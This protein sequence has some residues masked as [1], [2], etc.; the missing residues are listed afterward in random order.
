MT[1]IRRTPR[2]DCLTE[3]LQPQL[4][5]MSART[6]ELL[7]LGT[8]AR[9]AGLQYLLV[10]S[11]ALAGEGVN[12]CHPLSAMRPGSRMAELK[13]FADIIIQHRC[14]GPNFYVIFPVS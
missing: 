8:P 13:C 4:C 14:I 11:L 5:N 1:V 2:P 9:P 12:L 3:Q 6:A 10:K 7:A